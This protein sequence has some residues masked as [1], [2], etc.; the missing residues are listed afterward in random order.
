MTLMNEKQEA[1]DKT[2]IEIVGVEGPSRSK[3]DKTR[4]D[5]ITNYSFSINSPRRASTRLSTLRGP[6]PSTF[7]NAEASACKTTSLIDP[8]W[9]SRRCESLVFI[10]RMLFK[11]PMAPS[12][13]VWASF[14]A[15]SFPTD[16]R[17]VV[18][19]DATALK[20]FRYVAPS[21]FECATSNVREFRIA[22]LFSSTNGAWKFSVSI[23]SKTIIV[24]PGSNRAWRTFWSRVDIYSG[25]SWWYFVERKRTAQ[26]GES[27]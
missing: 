25:W 9:A 21:M 11:D 22:N 5:K 24:F 12:N 17:P 18:D 16:A 3:Q 2:I 27:W 15:M 8:N 23:N 4:Q 1:L 19:E 26:D 13:A 20:L 14:P 6:N 10:A 7:S